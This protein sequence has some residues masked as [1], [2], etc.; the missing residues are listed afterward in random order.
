M[1]GNNQL[2]I[3]R[4]KMTLEFFGDI[5]LL[6]LG[7]FYLHD[8]LGKNKDSFLKEIF[9]PMASNPDTSGEG[10]F[11]LMV[12]KQ[13]NDKSASLKYAAMLISCAYV[14]EAGRARERND[15][16]CAWSYMADARYW[17]GVAISSKGLEKAKAETISATQKN[18]S[19][20]ANEASKLSNKKSKEE[21]FRLIT[22]KWEHG[23]RW[24]TSRRAAGEIMKDVQVF[25][26]TLGKRYTNTQAQTTISGWLKEMPN[27]KS[28]FPKDK[29]S[30]MDSALVF[31][32]AD[33][34][35]V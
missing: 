34:S 14:V 3:S 1:T 28:L 21:A 12:S 13:E 23:K 22:E 20:K 15:R 10:Y 35:R 25:A 24:T 6:N 17:C 32:I 11:N 30:K 19:R 18:T 27:A 31:P 8:Q 5:T 26:E 2:S 33:I 16:E 9:E 29:A 7:S 4:D